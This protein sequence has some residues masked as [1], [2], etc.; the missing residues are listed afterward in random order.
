MEALLIIIVVFGVIVLA[1]LLSS[2]PKL[3]RL[4]L[5]ELERLYAGG[6][7]GGASMARLTAIDEEIQR[8][9]AADRVRM[10]ELRA[11]WE[12]EQLR[13]YFEGAYSGGF[14]AASEGVGDDRASHEAGIMGVL[15]ARQA[16]DPPLRGLRQDYDRILGGEAMNNRSCGNPTSGTSWQR[17][18]AK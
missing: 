14:D 3:D 10:K 4:T 8:R 17:C 7:S 1:A 16:F 9:D 11:S 2:T 6:L 15:K 13:A 5:P 18:R 12:G